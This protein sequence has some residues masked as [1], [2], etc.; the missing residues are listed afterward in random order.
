MLLPVEPAVTLDVPVVSVPEPSGAGSAVVCA[1]C[2]V[3]PVP[4]AFDAVTCTRIVEPESA[5]VSVYVLAVAPLIETQ[6]APDE[7]Q[8][9][10]W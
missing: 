2:A 9:S 7:S 5:D 1:D 10:H 6:F 3:C 8:R 4:S